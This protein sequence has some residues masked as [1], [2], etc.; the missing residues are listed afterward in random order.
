MYESLVTAQADHLTGSC[1]AALTDKGSQ[2]EGGYKV[3]HVLNGGCH[4][5]S[6]LKCTGSMPF[7]AGR[8]TTKPMIS[9]RSMRW[10]SLYLVC[11]FSNKDMALER[12]MVRSTSLSVACCMSFQKEQIVM[13]PP[14]HHYSAPSGR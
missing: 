4:K 9:D 5:Q 13:E 8:A 6:S 10:K 14:Y 1:D 7:N 11:N 12:F 3:R 2:I